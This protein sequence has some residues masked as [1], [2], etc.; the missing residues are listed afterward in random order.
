M[1]PATR[2]SLAAILSLSVVSF[3]QYP[4]STRPQSPTASP[5]PQS[6][7]NNPN[8][9]NNP[10]PLIEFGT[11]KELKDRVVIEVE[12][13]YANDITFKT[14]AKHYTAF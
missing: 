3:A 11:V 10:N 6:S 8:N 13:A 14:F 2:L 7:P 9:P 5:Y 12:C 1:R 4:T